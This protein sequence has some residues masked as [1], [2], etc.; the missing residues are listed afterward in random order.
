MVVDEGENGALRWN[1]EGPTG[2]TLGRKTGRVDQRKRDERGK[3]D[4]ISGF[5]GT[6]PARGGGRHGREQDIH[7]KK[8]V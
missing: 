7:R 4:L 6:P 2:S 3:Q 5:G 1:L 8:R